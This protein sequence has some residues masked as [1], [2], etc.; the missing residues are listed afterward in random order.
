M[1]RLDNSSDEVI[2]SYELD[3]D[4]DDPGMTDTVD[5]CNDCWMK[6]IDSPYEV[7][8]PSYADDSYHC[9]ECGAE[10]SEDDDTY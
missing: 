8:H 3:F 6:W 9:Y 5:L 4:P 10:L 2:S 1:P 7:E